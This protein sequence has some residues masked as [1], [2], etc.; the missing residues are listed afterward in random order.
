MT[1]MLILTKE[2]MHEDIIRKVANAYNIAIQ[3]SLTENNE[4]EFLTALLRI[5]W[6]LLLMLVK[7]VYD[8]FN[9]YI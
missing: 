6:L 3:I 1:V 4:K 8:N 7:Y 9:Y 2:T 5:Y